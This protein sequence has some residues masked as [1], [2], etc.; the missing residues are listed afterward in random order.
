MLV[1]ARS[2]SGAA[3]QRGVLGHARS[4]DLVRWQVQPPLTQ[5]DTGFW[6]LEVPQVEVDVRPGWVHI[7]VDEL[8]PGVGMADQESGLLPRL[9]QRRLRRGLAGVEVPARLHPAA[10]PLVPVQHRASQPDHD[11]RARYVNR[12]PMPVERVG[13]PVQFGQKACA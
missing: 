8:R 11:G 2:R 5:P 6:H 4:A 12:V 7:Q 9:P 10:Y 3:G 13:Q 1:T